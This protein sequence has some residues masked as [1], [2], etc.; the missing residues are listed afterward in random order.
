[1]LLIVLAC[2]HV[3]AGPA[4]PAAQLRSPYAWM[5]VTAPDGTGALLHVEPRGQ[6]LAAWPDGTAVKLL[7]DEVV[8]D[9][10]TWVRVQDPTMA[11]GWMAADRLAEPTVSVEHHPQLW[12]YGVRPVAQ[13]GQSRCP[14]GFPIK[15]NWYGRDGWFTVAYGPDFPRYEEHIPDTC[16]R[17]MEEANAYSFIRWQDSIPGSPNFPTPRPTP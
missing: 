7:G 2:L 1:M 9:G 8:D 14:P 17:S 11:N 13:D 15:G 3:T 6:I 16:F 12:K 10:A 4:E 5:L